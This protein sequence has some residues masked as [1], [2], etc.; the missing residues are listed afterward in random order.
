LQISRDR[1]KS[2]AIV[3]VAEGA[4]FGVDALSQYF[5][6]HREELGIDLRIT[7]LGHVQRGGA[8][9]VY[10]RLLASRFGAAA[11]DHLADGET[12]RLIGLRGGVIASTPLAEVANRATQ[13][14]AD[15]LALANTLAT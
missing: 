13:L 10:D 12:S 4:R 1:G 5:A 2:H 14:D 9:G 15:L 11:I 8:P 6:D 3:V 7:R